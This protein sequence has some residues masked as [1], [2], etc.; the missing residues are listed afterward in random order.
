[1]QLLALISAQSPKLDHWILF[2]LP[3]FLPFYLLS[4]QSPSPA[5]FGSWTFSNLLPFF[6]SF[7]HG[8]IDNSPSYSSFLRWS[9]QSHPGVN[10]TAELNYGTPQGHSL[11]AQQDSSL[12]F[13]DPPQVANNVI[14]PSLSHSIINLLY[15]FFFQMP[16]FL[17]FFA[18]RY[19]PKSWKATLLIS[20]H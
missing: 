5:G 7:Q 6:P 14:V 8:F 11:E 2:L 3:P 12:N 13:L 1:M 16:L 17:Y 19:F 10:G 18:S 9:T 15:T 20:C 4:Y